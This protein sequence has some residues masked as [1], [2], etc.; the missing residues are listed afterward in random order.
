MSRRRQFTRRVLRAYPIGLLAGVA[1]QLTS[2]RAEAQ[3]RYAVDYLHPAPILEGSILS[4]QGAH[5]ID[6]KVYSLGAWM[7]YERK[8]LSVRESIG[9]SDVGNLMGSVSTF[10]FLGGIGL[11]KQFDL[12][13]GAGFGRAGRG[14]TFG[15]APPQITG[16]A[17]QS[18]GWGLTDV[19][20]VPRYE[21]LR[22]GHTSFAVG[23]PMWLPTGKD[24]DYLGEPF[25]IE[26]KVMVDYATD[27]SLLILNVGYLV[28]KEQ[29]IAGVSVNDTLR[30]DLGAQFSVNR[31]WAGFATS[32]T[33]INLYE[34]VDKSADI[35]SELDGGV[36]F[37]T[38][39]ITV[40]GGLG[41]GVVSG[42]GSPVYRLFLSAAWLSSAVEATT[43]QDGDGIDDAHDACPTQ[44]E[45]RDGFQDQDGCPDL[46]N[47]GDKIV[48]TK[49]ACPDQAEDLDGI[50]DEDGC[51]ESD[52]D[53]DGIDDTNDKCPLV[54]E[55]KDGEQDD[56]GC[57]EDPS[58]QDQDGIVD[59][60]DQCPTVVG[61]AAEHGCPVKLAQNV[62]ISATRIDVTES[63]LFDK[64]TDHID[65]GSYRVVDA[66]AKVL[67]EHPEV[68]HVIIEGHTDTMGSAAANLALSLN[69]AMAVK[70]AL[71][72]R[73]IDANRLGTAG[74]GDK[75]PLMSNLTEEGRTKNRR[76][77]FIVDKRRTD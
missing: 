35:A 14:S 38:S 7:S 6:A 12:G 39:K 69:R 43:D 22:L 44:A 76:V 30:A 77:V 40:M 57:P 63:I 17:L 19:R 33:E 37:S 50:K 52:A 75:V 48:D 74:K 20:L 51:P 64:G 36:R 42:M 27:R 45:D 62:A 67:T 11:G 26:P 1:L 16:S 73:N 55:D 66:I 23:L 60:E 46:D 9:G 70:N 61:A 47:D 8:P 29:W 53:G 59:S 72:E 41:A 71:V 13:L 28:R 3:E 24:S 56:D 58:D 34:G 18:A 2:H 10:E 25:R 32:H 54:A 4:A 15:N 21:F 31:S 68:E 65:E 49:D 5:V